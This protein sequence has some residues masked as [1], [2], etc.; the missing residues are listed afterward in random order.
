ML[1]HV[2]QVHLSID[3]YIYSY[4]IQLGVYTFCDDAVV[5]EAEQPIRAFHVSKDITVNF[6]LFFEHPKNIF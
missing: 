1:T 5:F 4:S 2:I 3:E 6:Y